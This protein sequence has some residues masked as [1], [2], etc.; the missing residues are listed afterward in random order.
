MRMRVK[1]GAYNTFHSLVLPVPFALTLVTRA[2]AI[3]AAVAPPL[4][5]L[6]TLAASHF[7]TTTTTTSRHALSLDRPGKLR[8]MQAR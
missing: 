5:C 2:F 1:V 3:H 4:K 7:T 8:K 6:P